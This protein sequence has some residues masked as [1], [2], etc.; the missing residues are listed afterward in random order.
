M[1]MNYTELTKKYWIDLFDMCGRKGHDFTPYHLANGWA[2]WSE[3]PFRSGG[4]CRCKK[5]GKQYHMTS[6]VKYMGETL[7]GRIYERG[8]QI[9]AKQKAEWAGHK[10]SWIGTAPKIRR[11]KKSNHR[12]RRQK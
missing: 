7:K 2:W 5:S 8:P 4:I 6:S 11:R 12:E 10:E 1:G 9:T 3:Q